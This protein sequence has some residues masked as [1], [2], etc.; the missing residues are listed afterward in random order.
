MKKIMDGITVICMVLG[1]L[2][3][4]GIDVG[5][6]FQLYV[7]GLFIITAGAVQSLRVRLYG[8]WVYEDEEEE[9]PEPETRR[10]RIE[11]APA[12]PEKYIA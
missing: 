1:L 10:I 9:E 5:P 4:T 8:E 11:D 6:D 12:Q 3:A 7:T 2:L